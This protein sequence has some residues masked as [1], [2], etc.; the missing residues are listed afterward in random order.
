MTAY[1]CPEIRIRFTLSTYW[2]N[3][4]YKQWKSMKNIIWTPYKLKEMRH[5]HLENSK[6][7]VHR[8]T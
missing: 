7:T 6:Q 5:T 4:E 1:I 3:Y 8:S 2:S